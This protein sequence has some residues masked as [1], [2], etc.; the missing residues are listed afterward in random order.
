MNLKKNQLV[1]FMLNEIDK[2]MTIFLANNSSLECK[3]RTL[4]IGQMKFP[5]IG[6]LGKEELVRVN[7]RLHAY[8]RNVLLAE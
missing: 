8:Y 1:A 4:S 3:H 5:W 6:F 2:S 7:H